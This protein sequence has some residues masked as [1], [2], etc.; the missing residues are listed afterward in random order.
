[1]IAAGRA[2][3]GVSGGPPCLQLFELVL[4]QMNSDG[5]VTAGCLSLNK[6]DAAQGITQ[7]RHNHDAHRGENLVERKAVL[8]TKNHRTYHRLFSAIL[9]AGIRRATPNSAGRA[10]DD[11]LAR[12]CSIA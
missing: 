5:R 9:A 8:S 2:Y 1:M 12:P 6:T 3:I 7:H 11:L 10:D 4:R